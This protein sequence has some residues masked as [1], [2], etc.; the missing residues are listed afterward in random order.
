MVGAAPALLTLY[1]RAQVKESPVFEAQEVQARKP[2]LAEVLRA[3]SGRFLFAVALMTCFNFFSHGTQDLYPTFLRDQMKFNPH[4]TSAIAVVF[5]LGAIAGGLT[6]GMLSER[7]GRRRAIAA[8]AIFA[9]VPLWFWSHGTT[10]VVLAGA[11]FVM[12]FA[13]QGAWGVVPAY[14]NE[15][16]PNA[17]RG[18]FPGFAYQIGNLIAAVNGPLQTSIAKAHGGNYSFGLALV[19]GIVAVVLAGLALVGP[20]ARGTIFLGARP[21]QVPT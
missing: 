4:T 19:A 8:A 6:F 2:S 17:V 11:G 21:E 14:L 12:Q 18:T 1:I 10:P 5:N 16:S 9:L 13:V 15:L 20:E 7:I 3:N